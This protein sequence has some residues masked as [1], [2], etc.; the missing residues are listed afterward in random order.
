V[1]ERGRA[2]RQFLARI[3][4]RAGH[5]SA[6]MEI[7][8]LVCA[9]CTEVLP[10]TDAAVMLM[11]HPDDRHTL[12]ATSA[13]MS[14]V[15]ELQFSLG[16]GPSVEAFTSGGPVLVQDISVAD[17]R[18]PVFTGQRHPARVRAIYAFPLRQGGISIGVLSLARDRPAELTEDERAESLLT[19]DA[20]TL[21]MLKYLH[22]HDPAYGDVA[23]QAAA[24]MWDQMKVDEAIGMV[25]AQLNSSAAMA[26]A[27]LRATAFVRGQSLPEVAN[28]V[29]NRTLRFDPEPPESGR[30]RR[31]W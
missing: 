2:A 1:T 14:E 23:S 6:H 7:P 3:A 10:V 27:R 31:P 24:H 18:W 11:A 26:L 19:A 20:V 29:V 13:A 17:V 9:V 25:M 22:D 30:E 5:S 8:R 15:E 28:E 12:Q 4:G 21:T 16:E